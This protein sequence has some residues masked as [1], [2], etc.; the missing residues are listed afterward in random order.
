ME[1]PIEDLKNELRTLEELSKQKHPDFRKYDKRIPI[2]EEAIEVL[3]EAETSGKS[4][5]N[6]AD[7]SGSL[8]SYTEDECRNAVFDYAHFVI[9]CMEGKEKSQCVGAWF[10]EYKKVSNNDH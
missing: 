6:I 1:T 2:Y 7:V 4:A 10:D 3:K 8:P 5:L 9:K